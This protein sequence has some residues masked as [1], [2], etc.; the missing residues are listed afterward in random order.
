MSGRGSF[1][2][3]FLRKVKF[4]I[5][6]AGPP[7]VRC[8]WTRACR[9]VASVKFREGQALVG[10]HGAALEFESRLRSQITTESKMPS[11]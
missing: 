2:K 6:K 7:S 5:T 3:E 4:K 10:H 11:N 9:G 8:R 1:V